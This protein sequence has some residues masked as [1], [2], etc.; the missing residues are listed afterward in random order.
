MRALI[1]IIALTCIAAGAVAVEDSDVLFF[2]PFEDADGR[3]LLL[4]AHGPLEPLELEVELKGRLAGL[5]E[6]P[7]RDALSG[8]ALQWR[9]GKLQWPL[10]G[11]AV[12]LTIIE[13]AR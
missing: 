11:R 9:G 12:Q 2:A 6:A 4:I 3:A 8:E 1:C 13:P 10:P 5:R 7:A